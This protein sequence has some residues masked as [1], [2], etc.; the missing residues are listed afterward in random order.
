MRVAPVKTDDPA[1]TPVLRVRDLRV[2]FPVD[3]EIRALAVDGVS[4]DVS[5]GRTL[6]IVGESGCGKSVTA[7]SMLRL[8]P[9]PHARFESGR[10]ELLGH[11]SPVDLLALS[12]R[13][14]R[15]VRGGEIG[16]IFQE[17]MTS[18]NPVLTIGDQLREAI[19]IHQP[20]ARRRTR[21]LAIKALEAVE[22]HDAG[23]RLRAYP[24]EFSGGMRQRV[25]IAMALACEPRVLIADEPTTALDVT[26]Q[27]RV[28][29]LLRGL[30]RSRGLGMVLIT[31]D[32]GVVANTAHEVAVMY[33]GRIVERAP[34]DRLFA[35]PT[36]PYTRALLSCAPMLGARKD[37]LETVARLTDNPDRFAGLPGLAPDARAWWP[38]HDPP[39]EVSDGNDDS[40]LVDIAPGHGVR[41]WR[42]GE[43]SEASVG[44]RVAR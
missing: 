30:Q 26:V 19:G 41:V 39:S 20:G 12:E 38:W 33:A 29:E 5:A 32:L 11:G 9:M 31:H 10:V 40:T 36:H 25:M 37:R 43:A 22:I 18:L 14:M 2:S 16:M 13:E 1:A 34:A 4:L 3:S 24:H 17:P 15:R 7:L 35:S 42:S 23:A 27:A 28:L 21:A 6:G 44:R 8:L